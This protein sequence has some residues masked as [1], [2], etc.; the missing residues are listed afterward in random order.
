MTNETLITHTA[1]ASKRMKRLSRYIYNLSSSSAVEAF[2]LQ[3]LTPQEQEQ[4]PCRL[5]ILELLE[6]GV[7]QREIAEHLGVGI[8]TVT[9]G[10]RELKL[11]TRASHGD[12]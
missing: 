5:A 6:A 10:S 11:A 9:R 4:I 3:L 7:S 2:L 8:A 12:V 1:T